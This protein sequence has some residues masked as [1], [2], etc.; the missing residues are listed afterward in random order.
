M[1]TGSQQQLVLRGR[2]ADEVRDRERQ[3]EPTEGVE[4]D[5][6]ERLGRMRTEHGVDADAKGDHVEEE[7]VGE[8]EPRP[9][10]AP[11][12]VQAKWHH[13][14][15]LRR[16][17]VVASRQHHLQQ[18]AGEAIHDGCAPVEHARKQ[19]ALWEAACHKHA[20][21]E[22]K[23]DRHHVDAR[24]H[25]RVDRAASEVGRAR[26]AKERPA[27]ALV[28][29]GDE[30]VAPA[31]QIEGMLLRLV[32]PVRDRSKPADPMCISQREASDEYPGAK[33]CKCPREEHPVG[34]EP[35]HGAAVQIRTG[36]DLGA[37]PRDRRHVRNPVSSRK[38][39]PGG[40]EF[41][42]LRH[43]PPP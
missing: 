42:P 15:R 3:D 20:T 36:E 37:A 30:G 23:P 7:A 13:H 41:K 34:V 14:R 2:V 11:Y 8:A 12:D 10:G 24:C 25:P 33:E 1:L 35:R 31:A 43:H 38:N 19:E 16:A 28:Q 6:R 39:Y 17:R 32:E 40:G 9:P 22:A 21:T 27:K 26:V 4:R 5:G 29:S 18:M